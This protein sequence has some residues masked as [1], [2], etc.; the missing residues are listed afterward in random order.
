M[1][2][3]VTS[4]VR[5]IGRLVTGTSVSTVVTHTVTTTSSDVLTSTL[6]IVVVMPGTVME[7]MATTTDAGITSALHTESMLACTI[8]GTVVTIAT[9]ATALP[10]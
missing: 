3:Q 1:L 4:T 9:R 10:V 2:Q 6:P 8:A 5:C 7:V